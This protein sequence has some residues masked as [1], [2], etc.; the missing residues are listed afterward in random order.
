M[1]L[2]LPSALVLSTAWLASSQEPNAKAEGP[3]YDMR[4]GV[5]PIDTKA[6]PR[7][8]AEVV[9]PIPLGEVPIVTATV[10]TKKSDSQYLGVYAVSIKDVTRDGFRYFVQEVGSGLRSGDSLELN[11]IAIVQEP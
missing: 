7:R 3:K 1:K 5:T 4:L 9:F 6:Q 10:G 8:I 11:W 2:L